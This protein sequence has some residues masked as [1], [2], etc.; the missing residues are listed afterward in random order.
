[1]P[2]YESVASLMAADERGELSDENFDDELWG[3]L[4]DRIESP[5]DAA[6]YAEAVRVYFASRLLQWEVDNGGFAQAAYNI[7]EWFEPA[8]WAYEQLGLR[9]AAALIRE[10]V[11]LLDEERTTFTAEEIGGLF[12]QFA[13]SRLAALDERLEESDWWADEERLRYVRAHREAFASVT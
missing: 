1:M 10:A 9:K 2:G 12:Q 13:E 7:P 8:A 6:E 11:P 5:E 4:T 3:S